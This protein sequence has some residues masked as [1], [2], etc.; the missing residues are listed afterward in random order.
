MKGEKSKAQQACPDRAEQRQAARGRGSLGCSGQEQ[1]TWG[2]GICLVIGNEGPDGSRCFL[3]GS[4]LKRTGNFYILSGGKKSTQIHTHS[5]I[6]FPI[7]PPGE[8]TFAVTT[9]TFSKHKPNCIIA[10][11]PTQ[12]CQRT[13]PTTAILIVQILKHFQTSSYR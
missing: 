5:K 4:R 11:L 13:D 6:L 2:A 3:A 8:Q 1:T 10:L 12:V 9:D 7:N